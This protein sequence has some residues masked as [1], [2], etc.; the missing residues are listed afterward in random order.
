MLIFH[1]KFLSIEFPEEVVS[2]LKLYIQDSHQIPESG[3]ILM[4]KRLLNGNIIVTNITVPQQGDITRRHYF[5]KNKRIHQKI[6]DKL[7]VDSKRKIIYIGEWHTHPELI[8]HPSSVDLRGWRLSV[9]NQKDE[10]TYVFLIVGIKDF[11]LW[12]YSKS[13][14]LL[15]MEID[16]N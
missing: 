10:K 8:P 12:S 16:L 13:N 14:G 4:G 9:Q 15:K 6:S 7:W 3:G 11:G 1:N 5:K 2:S